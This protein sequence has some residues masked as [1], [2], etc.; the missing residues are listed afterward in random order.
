[1]IEI[2]NVQERVNTQ[3][4]IFDVSIFQSKIGPMQSGHSDS[5]LSSK[6]YGKDAYGGLLRVN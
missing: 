2:R 4:V 1:M 5:V 3:P 6:A